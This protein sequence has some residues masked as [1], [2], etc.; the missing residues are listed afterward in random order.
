MQAPSTH[1]PTDPPS[2]PHPPVSSTIPPS[3][4]H[5]PP[6]PGAHLVKLARFWMTLAMRVRVRAVCSS[7]YSC[8]RPKRLGDITAGQRNR[9]KSEALINRSAMSSRPR[10]AHRSRHEA[11]T[12]FSSRGNTL[13]GRGDTVRDPWWGRRGMSPAPRTHQCELTT[14]Q[15]ASSQHMRRLAWWSAKVEAEHFMGSTSQF[16]SDSYS[17]RMNSPGWGRGHQRGPGTTPLSH[18]QASPMGTWP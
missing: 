11:K 14:L 16:S 8:M 3:N 9:R 12:S 15:R 1:R 5:H 13:R 17:A 6:P 10:S 7:G 4:H 2:P 18:S